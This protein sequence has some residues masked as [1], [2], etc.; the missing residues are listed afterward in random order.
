[1]ILRMSTNKLGGITI[2]AADRD[3]DFVYYYAHLDHYEK[4]LAPGQ[5]IHKGDILGYVGTTGNAPKDTPHLHFQIMIWAT[6]GKWW[7]GE[8]INPYPILHHA[9][10]GPPHTR[11]TNAPPAES[12]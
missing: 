1:V 3:K 5:S 11:S 7:D 8:P 6:D 9:D 12:P 2:Y 10:A 4:D